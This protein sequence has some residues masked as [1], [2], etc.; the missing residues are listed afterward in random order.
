MTTRRPGSR[1]VRSRIPVDVETEPAPTEDVPSAKASDD[2]AEKPA[3]KTSATRTILENV[4]C[5]AIA[6]VKAGTYALMP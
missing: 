5:L 1:K 2:A 4:E 6:I 3:A